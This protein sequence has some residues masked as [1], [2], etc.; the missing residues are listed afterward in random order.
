M[1]RNFDKNIPIGPIGP[2]LPPGLTGPFG[3]PTPPTPPTPPGPITPDCDK[4]NKITSVM[5]LPAI[6][7]KL[8]TNLTRQ[9]ID[10]LCNIIYLFDTDELISLLKT[11]KILPNALPL[12]DMLN[13]ACKNNKIPKCETVNILFTKL[14]SYQLIVEFL[15]NNN[16]TPDILSSDNISIILRILTNGGSNTDNIINILENFITKNLSMNINDIKNILPNDNLKFIIQC[17]CPDIDSTITCDDVKNLLKVILT[18]ENAFKKILDKNG[19]NNLDNINIT[20]DNICDLLSIL[21]T[22]DKV[23]NMLQNL[24]INYPIFQGLITSKQIND[25]LNCICDNRNKKPVVPAPPSIQPVAPSTHNYNLIIYISILMFMISLIPISMV[26]FGKFTQKVLWIVF[27]LGF[28]ILLTTIIILIN[29]NCVFK[30]CPTEKDK[31]VMPEKGIYSGSKTMFYGKMNVN[32]TIDDK[33]NI[34]LNQLTVDKGSIIYPNGRDFLLNCTNKNV[35]VGDTKSDNG[36]PVQG[37]CID[38]IYKHIPIIKGIWVY[39]TNQ[40]IIVQVY[41]KYGADLIVDIPIQKIN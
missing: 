5:I 20:N 29:P 33:N 6:N 28:F 16:F 3:P 34:I 12:N 24:F 13:C 17:L 27:I 32:V 7:K 10:E 26:Y 1:F 23:D 9:N 19:I 2:I 31:W 8:G 41:V 14:I 18:N 22:D 4:L 30:L 40:Q 39:R 11:N 35:Y 25:I 36:Y 37:E 38:N 15:E 21:D